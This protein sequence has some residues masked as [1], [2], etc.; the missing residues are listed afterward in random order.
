MLLP[1]SGEA[2]DVK[3]LSLSQAIDLA[4]D[5][6][7]LLKIAHA[8][9]AESRY[10]ESQVKADYYPHLTDDLTY[11]YLSNKQVVQIPA[12]SIGTVPGLGEF[13]ADT[14]EIDQ[15]SQTTLLN[16]LTLR[17][18]LTQIIKIADAEDVASAERQISEAQLRQARAEIIYA[19]K[20]LFYGL[21]LAKE[22]QQNEQTTI[23]AAQAM[24]AEV[25]NAEAGG[26]VLPVAVT[27][28]K[29]KL[30]EAKQALLTSQI[31]SADL[32]A[33]LSKLLGQPLD[34]E[35]APLPED[36]VMSDL[37]PRQEIINQALHSNPDIEAAYKQVLKANSGVSAAQHAHLPDVGLFGTYIHQD[38]ISFLKEDIGMVGI[39]MNWDV[40][41]WGKKTAQTNQ[42]KMQLLQAQRHLAQV[43]QDVEVSISKAYRKLE[44]V[45]Q[46]VNVA[47]EAVALRRELLRQGDDQ[48]QVET[49][50]PAAHAQLISDL[51]TAQYK[52]IQA[53]VA[54]QLARAELLKIAGQ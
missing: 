46:L 28:A 2:S 47:S 36:L 25:D 6:S 24:L 26:V 21:V 29:V 30:M 52:H 4:L 1:A 11:S 40:F 7:N 49:I 17:Q 37:P 9:V 5:N 23:A 41:D 50:T 16:A 54:Y 14:V 48:L 15:G 12:G 20:R 18:P 19:V 33:D 43:Q 51:K 34:S 22:Q 35:Y 44:Q 53:Q 31:Q 10:K 42:R 32:S 39:Q 8:K 13:P 45:R 38:G 27:A 3:P